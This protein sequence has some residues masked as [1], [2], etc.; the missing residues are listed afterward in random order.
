MSA[1]LSP[2]TDALGKDK[3]DKQGNNQ[4]LFTDASGHPELEVA[5]AALCSGTA[6]ALCLH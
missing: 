2:A 3:W 6:N 4:P 1:V 5:P